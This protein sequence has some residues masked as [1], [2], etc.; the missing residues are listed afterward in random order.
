MRQQEVQTLVR[1]ELGVC[2]A[3]NSNGAGMDSTVKVCVAQLVLSGPVSHVSTPP[4]SPTS[5]AFVL[6]L[7]P[8]NSA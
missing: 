8:F 2:R 3:G 7:L 6:C 1:V 4:R 5:P